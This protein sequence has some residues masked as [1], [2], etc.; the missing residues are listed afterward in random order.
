MAFSQ[1]ASSPV[2]LGQKV[3][4]RGRG[5]HKTAVVTVRTSPF[6]R[7]SVQIR[8]GK[9]GMKRELSYHL[10]GKTLRKV[11]PITPIPPSSNRVA[12]YF[13]SRLHLR[14]Y[15][16]QKESRTS[17]PHCDEAAIPSIHHP[18]F[19]GFLFFRL[20]SSRLRLQKHAVQIESV[21]NRILQ[22]WSKYHK[23][24]WMCFQTG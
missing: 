10:S 2:P 9:T 15:K 1:K 22:R 5:R 4:P 14:M 16:S 3:I 20:R 8:A 24:D 7:L 18:A 19:F 21:A 12:F 23:G 6:A 17:R 13:S 11:L